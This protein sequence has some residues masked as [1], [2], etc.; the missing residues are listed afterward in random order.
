MADP[1]PWD[2]RAITNV[3]SSQATAHSTDEMVNSA[4]PTMKVR[5]RPMVSPSRPPSSISPPKVST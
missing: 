5:L 4:T 3:A 2:N 1:T